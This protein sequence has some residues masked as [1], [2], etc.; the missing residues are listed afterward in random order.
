M[1]SIPTLHIPAPLLTL[2]Q[3]LRLANVT[4]VAEGRTVAP[5]RFDG[6]KYDAVRVRFS[7]EFRHSNI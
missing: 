3:A 7:V 6:Y 1:K 5:A 2:R 4:V